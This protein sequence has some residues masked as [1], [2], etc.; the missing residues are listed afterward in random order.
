MT[1]DNNM[2]DNIEYSQ[3]RITEKIGVLARRETEARILIPLIQALGEALGR[4][5][6]V[7]TVSRTII[8]IARDQGRDLAEA[9]G[10]NTAADFKEALKFWTKDDALE[11]EIL[12]INGTRLRFNVTRCRYAQMYK[13]LGAQDLGG[14]FSC[15]RDGA[16]I[17]GFNPHAR[18]IRNH[19][20]M[21]GDGICDF[22]YQFPEPGREL[23]S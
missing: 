9:M 2:D 12:E 8:K 19:T 22:E 5:K 13:A 23:T 14:V 18:M 10:G 6:V 3:D 21:A 20:I 15:N 11:M 17:S 7:D 1:L 16:L 4:E